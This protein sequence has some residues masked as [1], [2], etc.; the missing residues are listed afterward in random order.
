ML[1]RFLNKQYCYSTEGFWYKNLSFDVIRALS[2]SF[3]EPAP[4][5]LR[6]ARGGLFFAEYLGGMTFRKGLEQNLVARSFEFD[7]KPL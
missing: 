2:P 4:N 6:G 3:G 5:S 1:T 7:R